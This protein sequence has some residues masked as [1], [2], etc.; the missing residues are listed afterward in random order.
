VKGKAAVP[1]LPVR[2]RATRWSEL[3]DLLARIDTLVEH[4]VA[5]DALHGVPHAKIA[6][7]AAFEAEI[8]RVRT[9]VKK[10][11]SKLTVD[12][13]NADLADRMENKR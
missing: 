2:S 9:V 8:D 3:R 12:R 1:A 4:N 7:V 11:I 6:E 5:I 10:E 13:L